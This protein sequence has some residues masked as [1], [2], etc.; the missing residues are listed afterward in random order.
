MFCYVIQT[1]NHSLKFNQPQ[2]A[3]KDVYSEL[4]KGFFYI[5][6]LVTISYFLFLLRAN[7]TSCIFFNCYKNYSII[8]LNWIIILGPR[9]SACNCG[10]RKKPPAWCNNFTILL[11]TANNIYHL[12]YLNWD[13]NWMLEW[14]II[15]IYAKLKL[16]CYLQHT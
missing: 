1:R 5:R 3:A 16:I 6:G 2:V 11:R 12:E 4:K 9:R 10:D 14:Y 13:V 15:Y 8:F 7:K